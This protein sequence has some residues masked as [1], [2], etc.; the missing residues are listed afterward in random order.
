MTVGKLV[1]FCRKCDTD[2]PCR[3]ANQIAI[4]YCRGFVAGVLGSRADL[5]LCLPKDWDTGKAL[6]LFQIWAEQ[7]PE[8]KPNSAAD[9][10][11]QAHAAAFDCRKVGHG[12]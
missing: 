1:N 6:R 7:H 5:R 12:I 2:T 10:I 4:G 8:K 11:M 3:E 9:E